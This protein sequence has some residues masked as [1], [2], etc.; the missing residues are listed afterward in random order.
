[1]KLKTNLGGVKTELQ[2]DLK[3]DGYEPQGLADLTIPNHATWQ[4]R[5]M[6]KEIPIKGEPKKREQ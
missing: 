4:N 3:S 5:K 1:V 2:N 6:K